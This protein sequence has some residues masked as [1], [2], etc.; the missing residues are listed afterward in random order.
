VTVTDAVCLRHLDEEY[1]DLC[2]RVLG[3]LGRKRPSPLTRGPGDLTLKLSHHDGEFMRRDLVDAS[4]L[5]WLA[6]VDGC[7]STSGGLP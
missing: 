4:P 6:E 1:A 3:K 2:R 5:T 7:L